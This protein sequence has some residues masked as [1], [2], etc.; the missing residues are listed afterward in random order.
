MTVCDHVALSQLTLNYDNTDGI[1]YFD[2]SIYLS[3]SYFLARQMK[4]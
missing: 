3:Q 1:D 2:G 4:L